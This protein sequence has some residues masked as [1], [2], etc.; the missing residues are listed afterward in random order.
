MNLEDEVAAAAGVLAAAGLVDAF[1]HVSARVGEG[2]VMTPARPL[3]DVG[4]GDRLVAFAP[5]TDELP[6]GTPKEAWVHLGIYEARPDVS[7][8]CRAQPRSVMAA[9]IS[10]VAIRALHGQGAFVGREVPVFDDARL[11][12]D[13]ERS[14]RL[15][16][17]LGDSH[18]LVMRGN[19]AIT[20]GSGPGIA[21]ARMYVLEAS[22]RL[23]LEAAAVGRESR[24]LSEEEF[25]AWAEAADEILGRLWAH[26]RDRD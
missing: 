14:R 12:R 13:R 8:I 6:A 21:T 18:A 19:G 15:A 5:G 7:A 26:L 3:G 25:E 4:P 16:Q 2:I 1:G 20:V 17:T 22:A 9:G 10:G 24:P 11:V 23:N